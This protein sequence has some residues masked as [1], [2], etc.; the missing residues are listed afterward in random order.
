MH[1]GKRVL[2]LLELK[3]KD[4]TWLSKVTNIPEND[5]NTLLNH[6]TETYNHLIAI[7]Q[8]LGVSIDYLLGTQQQLTYEDEDMLMELYRQ[9]NQDGKERL[10]EQ[11]E[12]FAS[13]GKYIKNYEFGLV[14]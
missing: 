1:F 10:L 6:E 11:A 7:S 4:L 8:A 12:F 3:H 9:L 5:L 2:Q 13:S 14:S